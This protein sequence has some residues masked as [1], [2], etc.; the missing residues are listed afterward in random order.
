MNSAIATYTN[1]SKIIINPNWL[2]GFIEGEDTFGIKTGS[3][4]YLQV[5]QK[6]TSKD[7]LNA[8][9]KFLTRLPSIKQN[10]KIS[11][12]NVVST[13]NKKQM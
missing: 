10:S 2:I 1:T 4:L 5:A 3:S 7:S 6:T 13:V 9:T 12:L 8:I 11:S